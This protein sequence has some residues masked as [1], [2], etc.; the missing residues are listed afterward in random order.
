MSKLQSR[1]VKMWSATTPNGLFSQ[2]LVF[3]SSIMGFCADLN[4]RPFNGVDWQYHFWKRL[5]NSKEIET[6][7]L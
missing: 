3:S 2:K 6:F 1:S 4:G 5:P 7:Y